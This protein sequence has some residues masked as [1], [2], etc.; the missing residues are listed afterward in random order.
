MTSG[1]DEG[2]LRR[3]RTRE[4]GR[5]EREDCEIGATSQFPY[6]HIVE[7]SGSGSGKSPRGDAS[8]L[9][10]LSRQQPRPLREEPITLAVFHYAAVG[11][12]RGKPLVEGCVAH[13]APRSELGEW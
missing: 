3:G 6:P 4:L 9:S 1:R 7:H 10:H 11:S 12:E 5:E 2:M 13:A 8:G